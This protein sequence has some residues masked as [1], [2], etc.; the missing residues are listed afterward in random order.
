MPLLAILSLFA[1]FSASP[2]R[3]QHVFPR[4]FYE[5]HR[6]LVAREGNLQKQRIALEAELTDSALTPERK[7]AIESEIEDLQQQII[8][9]R[10]EQKALRDETAK[11]NPQPSDGPRA[12]FQHRRKELLQKEQDLQQQRR[13]IAEERR[14][15]VED[16]EGQKRLAEEE[17]RIGAE[18]E[19]LRDEHRRLHEEEDARQKSE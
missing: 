5:K 4:E 17:R 2:G 6:A 13:K 11:N 9:V 19:K 1:P 18:L 15:I 8:A 14:E 10:A 3:R 12:S 7:S 16:L